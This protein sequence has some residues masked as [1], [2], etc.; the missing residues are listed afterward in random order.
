[1]DL[2]HVPRLEIEEAVARANEDPAAHGIIIYYPVFGG[3]RDR[4]LQD[5]VAVE[6]DVEGL[7]ARWA[8][9]LYHDVRSVNGARKPILP[10]TPLAIVKA[11]EHLD[12]YVHDAPTGTQAR[13][14]TATIFN[15]SEVVG[16]PLAAMLAHDGAR[17]FSFDIDGVLV[18]DGAKT[19]ESKISRKDALAQSDIVITGVPSRDFELVKKDEIREGAV[20]INFS[21]YKNIDDAVLERARAFLPRVGPITVAMLLRNTLRLFENYHNS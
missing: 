19:E 20:C 2:I 17:V 21:T 7:N 1:F 13:G 5:E 15:R 12:V 16:R 14:K 11:L 9:M 8:Y 18:Y 10:C 6:K 3:E 4:T